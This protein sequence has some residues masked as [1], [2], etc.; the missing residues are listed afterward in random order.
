MDGLIIVKKEKGFTSFD[1][2]AKLRGILGEKKI[3]HLGTLDPEAEGVLPVLV[4][5]ATRLAPLMGE[6]EKVYR[7]TLLLGIRTD[8]QDTTGRLLERRPVSCREEEVR[9]LIPSFIGAQD[10][11]PPMV[12]A[13][14]VEGQRLYDLARQGKEVERKS[15]RIHIEDI[16]ILSVDLPR[17]ELRVCCSAGTYIRT[18]CHDIGEKLGCGGAMETLVRE[19]AGP[20]ELGEA[21]SLD[22][23]CSLV[24]TD[25]LHK[26]MRSLKDLLRQYAGFVCTAQGEKYA[27]NG[28]PLSLHLGTL[29]KPVWD[30]FC[31]H[32]MKADRTSIG[33]FRFKE[34]QN[35]LLPEVMIPPEEKKAKAAPRPSVVSLGKFDGVH[36]GH[37]AIIQEMLRQAEAE[38]LKT[39][40]FSFTNPPETMTQ[41]RKE[42]LLTTAEEKRLLLKEMGIHTLVEARFTRA[43]RDM[44]AEQFLKDILIGR[45]GMKK[46]VVGPDCSFGKDRQGDVSY[47]R[48]HASVLG[49]EVTVVDKIQMDGDIVSSSRIKTLVK[50]GKMEAAARLLG[51]PFA[52]R[53]RVGYGRH[54]GETLGFPTINVKMP[55]EKVFP[56]FGVYASLTETEEGIHPGMS[57][58]GIKPTVEREGLPAIETH[59]LDENLN[60]YGCLCRQQLLSYIRPEQTFSSLDALTAQLKQDKE[61]LLAYFSAASPQRIP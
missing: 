28:N 9:A 39:L 45:Y 8:T 60:R 20:Y 5:R 21:I 3:G 10:Q 27:S 26:R 54:L 24:L 15:C 13:K 50:E 36:V 7:C 42:E 32:V 49:Y 19:A 14:K 37:Q 6:S 38:K 53:G 12:S 33:L 48:K 43:M 59:L 4:G 61:Q 35:K 17:V 16:Q 1:V 47:L 57:N 2:V 44:P 56:P 41:H 23:I 29:E 31:V 51:R 34:S 22:E 55:P 30:G 58:F 18:L 52:L 40:L 11:L 46:I 25:S